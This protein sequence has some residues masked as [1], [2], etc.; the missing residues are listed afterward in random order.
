VTKAVEVII[1]PD[2]AS[3]SR[4]QAEFHEQGVDIPLE[5]INPATLWNLVAEFVTREWEEIGDTHYS[6]DD[7]ISQVLE[8]LQDGKAKVVFDLETGTCNIVSGDSIV[9]HSRQG[10][11]PGGKG[12]SR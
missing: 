8:Q 3:S 4:R 10:C 5:R 1:V 2:D 12:D 9:P 6:L 7:K 11:C